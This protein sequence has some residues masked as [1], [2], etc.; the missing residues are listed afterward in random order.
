MSAQPDDRNGLTLGELAQRLGAELR[1]DPAVL[2]RSLATLSDAQAGQLGFL[3]NPLY[4][5][6]LATTHA[7]AVILAA[8]LADEC[9]VACLISPHPYLTYA[10]ASHLFNRRPRQPEGIHPT[11]VVA[12][13]AVLGAGCRIG[14]HVVIESGCVLGERV[15]V[16]PGTCIGANSRIGTDCVLHGNV[17]IYHGVTIGERCTFHG[18]VVIGADGF[19]FANEKGAWRKI[20]QLGGVRIGNDV[21]VGAST[22][23]DRGALKDTLIGDNVILDNQIQIAHNVEI[24]EGTAIAGCTG[25]AGS[26]KIGRYCTI[27]GAVGIAGH[28]E[29][30]DRVHL[31]MRSAITNSITEPGSYSSGTAMSTTA[32]WRK[33]AVRFR[34]LD[35]MARHIKQ[36]EKRLKALEA[37]G[38][39]D[40]K[41]PE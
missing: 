41:A 1:G 27:A 4:R 15:E 9:P 16:G 33:N 31:T 38:A 7:S 29:I 19:G 39:G 10:R 6:Q 14:P 35:E 32:E 24:G 26:T 23:I 28:I 30:A 21:E 11:A 40:N 3:A 8:E 17:T 25:I 37:V 22:T 34:Q 18:G 36:L 2:I 13:D 12:T 20:A 5:A